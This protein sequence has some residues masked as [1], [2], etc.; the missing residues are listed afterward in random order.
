[1]TSLSEHY[2]LYTTCDAL[3]ILM[4]VGEKGKRGEGNKVHNIR[5]SPLTIIIK[6]QHLHELHITV[7][8]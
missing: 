5:E 1:M 3:I 4:R 2:D 6:L 7:E 8:G